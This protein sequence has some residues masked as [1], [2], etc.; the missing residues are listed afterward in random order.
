MSLILIVEDDPDVSAV[1]EYNLR[2][3]GYEPLVAANGDQGLK[4]ARETKPD[5]V[6]LDLMLPDRSGTEV[7]RELKADP[8]TREI[9][10][11]MVTAKCDEID[12][13]VGFELGI[14]DYV[15]KPFS[16]REL[17]LRIK[18]SLERHAQP[19]GTPAAP[20]GC[21]LTVD[22]DAHRV[23]VGGRE[24]DLS[25]LEFRLLLALFEKQNRVLTREALVK[26]VWGRDTTVSLRTVDAHVK[27]V[28]SRLGTAGSWIETVRGVGYR[29]GITPRRS[30]Q[31]DDG[32]PFDD[33]EEALDPGL[34]PV[35]RN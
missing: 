26:L 16:V 30:R 5:L 24:C 18:R 22:R 21:E 13:V 27:R 23:F 19:E 31:V 3:A 1:I 29:F 15:T 8:H 6:L 14:D 9:P 25:A 11:I 2:G 10:I 35:V 20:I 34:I 4:Y 32:T 17:L 28:R 33:E 12:R 7:C